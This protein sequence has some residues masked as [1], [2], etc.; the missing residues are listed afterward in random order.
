MSTGIF[1]VHAYGAVG[2]GKVLDTKAIQAAINACA[3]NGGGRVVIAGGTFRSGTLVLKSHV[4]LEIEAG[5]TLLGSTNLADYP[6]NIPAARSFTD[7]YTDKSLIYVEKQQDIA[8]MGRGV[9]KG[10][11]QDRAFQRKPMKDRPYLIRVI[12][13]RNVSV[14]DVTLQDSPMWVQ[15]Y[16]ACEGVLID[17]ITVHSLVN[18]NND[19]IDIDGCEKVRIANCN[20]E[21]GD[22]G[23][24]LK[25]TSQRPCRFV[26]VTN[27]VVRSLCNAFKCGTESNGGF[28]DITVS[29]CAIYDTSLAGIALELVDG[30]DFERVILSGITMKNAKGGIF[31]RLGNRGRPFGAGQPKL[32]IGT[33]KDIMIRDVQ[34]TGVN[35]IGCSITGLPRHA[36]ENITLENIR[37][38]Y[39]GGSPAATISRDVP[40]KQDSY[41]EFRMFGPLP[42]YGLYVRHARNVRLH[43]VDFTFQKDDPRPPMVFDNVNDIELLGVKAQVTRTTPAYFRFTNVADALIQGCRPIATEVPFLQVDGPESDRIRLWNNDVGRVKET[44]LKGKEVRKE[45]I[46]IR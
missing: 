24:C 46:E 30:G 29:N 4:T 9:I 35:A 31:V 2:D 16:L 5:A 12:E 3:E 40:E 6:V 32:K 19:G 15:H 7:K 13:C 1:N 44:V 8:I 22:D 26:T 43:H 14:R 37:I 36:V 10:Q 38:G 21:S 17:G 45:A 23:I 11:G 18:A 39:D 33:M 28:Q 25:S 34:A 27:C 20:I 41:P 42:A